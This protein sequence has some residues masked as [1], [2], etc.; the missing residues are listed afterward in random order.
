MA[1]A[2]G[3]HLAFSL[4]C[5]SND[6]HR[7][8]GSPRLMEAGVLQTFKT[9]NSAYD[10][11]CAEKISFKVGGSGV[12]YIF[13]D[14]DWVYGILIWLGRCLLIIT[15]THQGTLGPWFRSSEPSSVAEL[16]Q[17]L[18]VR[19]EHI[20]TAVVVGFEQAGRCTILVDEADKSYPI[21][22]L[23]PHAP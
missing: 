11:I 7:L 10:W 23:I 21:F 5:I 22:Y 13:T 18:T 14:A 6:L 16:L 12:W 20:F 19:R 15:Q 17:E 9:W 3:V 4:S 8:E 2:R 1:G